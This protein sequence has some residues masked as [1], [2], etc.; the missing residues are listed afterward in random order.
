MMGLK[1]VS[2]MGYQ[3]DTHNDIS[4]SADQVQDSQAQ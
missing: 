2:L 3:V 1:K 4:C